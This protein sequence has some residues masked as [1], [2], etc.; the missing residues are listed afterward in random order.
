MT[1][2]SEEEV[3]KKIKIAM[4][5]MGLNQTSLAK[6][7]GVKPN[8]V[9]QWLTG[10]NAPKTDTIKKIAKATGKPINYFF[11]EVKGNNIAVGHGAKTSPTNDATIQVLTAQVQM[12]MAKV[13]LLEHEVEVLKKKNTTYPTGYEQ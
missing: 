2:K 8:T 6:K 3:V 5:E 11:A 4:A 10:T 9:S 7:L 1:R 12:L 13:K